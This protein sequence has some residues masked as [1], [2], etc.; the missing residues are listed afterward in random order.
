MIITSIPSVSVYMYRGYMTS[1]LLLR[2]NFHHLGPTHQ[3]SF[4]EKLALY[5]VIRQEETGLDVLPSPL[6]YSSSGR[7][8]GW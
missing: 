2:H 8:D 6:H 1:S 4:F 3:D 7:E 5:I